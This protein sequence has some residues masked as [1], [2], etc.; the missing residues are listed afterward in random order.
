MTLA[1]RKALIDKKIQAD[2][3]AAE[4]KEKRIEKRRT[5]ALEEIKKLSPRIKEIIELANYAKKNGISLA[6]R[7]KFGGDESYDTDTFITNGWSHLVG[8]VNDNPITELGITAGGACGYID[9]RTDGIHTYGCDTY[10]KIEVEAPLKYLEEFVQ[11]FDE[12]ESKF[13]AFIERICE[14]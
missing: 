2:K 1:E 7:R 8:F 5:E 14:V 12:L 11:T 3:S 4:T 10:K 9:F 13:N 6:G